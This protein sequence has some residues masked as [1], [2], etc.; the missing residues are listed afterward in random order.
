MTF[1]PFVECKEL[2]RGNAKPGTK[3][4]EL[5]KTD[6]RHAC[7]PRRSTGELPLLVQLDWNGVKKFFLAAVCN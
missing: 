1:T 5:A 3:G 7:V 4:A 6:V 2:G